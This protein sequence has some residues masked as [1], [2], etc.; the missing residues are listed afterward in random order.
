MPDEVKY[1]AVLGTGRTIDSPSGLARRTFTA[2]GRVD[3]SLRRDLTWTRSSEIYQWERGEDMGPD[4]VEISEDEAD[5]LI[6]RFRE[7]W[8]E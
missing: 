2:K 3:E 6:E 4:L 1:F 5:A 7:K 8:A